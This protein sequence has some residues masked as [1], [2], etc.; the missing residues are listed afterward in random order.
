MQT[1]EE[2]KVESIS[3]TADQEKRVALANVRIGCTL[4]RGIAIWRSGNGRLRVYLPSYRLG[5]IFDEAV[6]LPDDLRTDVEAAVIA[7]FKEAKA[8]AEKDPNAD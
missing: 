1:Q 3:F 8:E 5:R 6:Q 7:A 4:I 2:F